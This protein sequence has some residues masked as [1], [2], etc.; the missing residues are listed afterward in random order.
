[1]KL[2]YDNRF[3]WGFFDWTLAIVLAEYI[4]LKSKKFVW[5]KLME[6]NNGIK[7]NQNI[8]L[9]KARMDLAK[10]EFPGLFQ[11]KTKMFNENSPLLQHFCANVANALSLDDVYNAT[12]AFEI[13]GQKLYP[14][15]AQPDSWS[16]FY[17]SCPNAQAVRNRYRMVKH[18]LFEIGGGEV[19]S[20][21]SGSAQ[22]LIHALYELN[23]NTQLNLT[24]ISQDALDLAKARAEQFGVENISYHR[25]SLKKIFQSFS[26][27]KFDVVEACGI[28]D[29]FNDDEA[30]KILE[31][32][33]SRTSGSIIVSNM[34]KTRGG[35]LL[36]K[37]YNWPIIYRTPGEFKLLIQ[38]AGGK[39]VKIYIEP[40][41]IHVV[42]TAEVV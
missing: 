22:P 25:M 36:L 34:N 32:A 30:V 8:A 31:F 21:A 5:N 40:W 17:L 12:G 42:A 24:D 20:I 11:I 7:T 1:M 10:R 3:F 6:K 28:L 33:L 9:E 27:K 23:N 29:Y 26:E 4:N 38:K 18:L 41:N 37:T 39:N 2:E 15:K 13:N 14:L 16:N 35:K 19:L